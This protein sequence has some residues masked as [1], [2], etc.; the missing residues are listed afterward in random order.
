MISKKQE[1]QGHGKNTK[2]EGI[3][4]ENMKVIQFRFPKSDNSLL[5]KLLT[6]CLKE[7]G[8]YRTFKNLYGIANIYKT[9]Y[10]IYQVNELFDIN[11]EIEYEC[12]EC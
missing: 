11:L 6:L 1:K 7:P 10:K 8:I 3:A 5:N 12:F 2:R 4:A 9:L